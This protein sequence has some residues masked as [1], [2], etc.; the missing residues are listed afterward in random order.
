LALHRSESANSESS[1]GVNYLPKIQSVSVRRR[2]ETGNE[3]A[4]ADRF[5]LTPRA[6]PPRD[7]LSNGPLARGGDARQDGRSRAARNGINRRLAGL[8]T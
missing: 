3:D 6:A 8:V 2:Y 4:V 7:S 5:G 1:Y